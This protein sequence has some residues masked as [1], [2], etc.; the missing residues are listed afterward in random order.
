M[1][2]QRIIRWLLA[3]V[4]GMGI[5]GIAAGII[6][7]QMAYKPY[8]IQVDCRGRDFDVETIKRW[9]EREKDGSMGMIRI[10]GWR[11]ESQKM[12][13]SV[14]TGRSHRAYILCVYGSMEL[15]G[16]AS[17]LSGR[18]GLAVEEDYCVLTESLARQLFGGVDV[19][20]Q[21][22]EMER[23]KMVV[24]GVVDTDGDILM[25]PVTEG[26]MEQVAVEFKGRMGAKEKMK[27][28]IEENGN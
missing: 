24:A 27:G 23:T 14:S 12:V 6:W 3:A 2:G 10:A 15:V 19:A 11:I 20:G 1:T 22:V 18:Y 9:E 8:C 28:M 7:Y 5:L 26:R 13:A 21:W 16:K 17:I 25:V 4:L